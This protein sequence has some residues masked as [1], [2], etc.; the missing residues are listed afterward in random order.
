M[1]RDLIP[2]PLYDLIM[3]DVPEELAAL[4]RLMLMFVPEDEREEFSGKVLELSLAHDQRFYVHELAPPAPG[5]LWL[6]CSPK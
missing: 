5:N 6:K 2:T 3:L 4:R 1:A